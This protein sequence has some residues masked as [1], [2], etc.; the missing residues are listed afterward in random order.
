MPTVDDHFDGKPDNVRKVYDRLVALAERFGPVKQDPK[1]T[2]IHLNRVTAFAGIAVRKDHIVL[3]IK[4]DKPVKSKRIV[5][6]QHT[7]AKRFHHDV[8]LSNLKD[9]DAELR[10][11]L[12]EAFRLSG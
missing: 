8:R 10:G 9:V 5:R 4:S 2:C 7:S 12:K 1:K 11:W 6:T 3:T